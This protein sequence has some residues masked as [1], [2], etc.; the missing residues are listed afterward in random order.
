MNIDGKYK[1]SY[2]NLVVNESDTTVHIWNVKSGSIVE[3][4]KPI[5]NMLEQ[6]NFDGALAEYTDALIK[7]GVIVHSDL[8]EQQEISF[9]ANKGSIPQVTIR[10]DL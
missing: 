10:L 7:E 6:E 8:N 3:L 1:Q 5:Y 9:C 4:E 2:Y